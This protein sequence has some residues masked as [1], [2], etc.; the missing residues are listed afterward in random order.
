[1][2]C[3]RSDWR[4]FV[5][6]G[7]AQ[8]NGYLSY[9]LLREASCSTDARQNLPPFSDYVTERVESGSTVVDLGCGPLPK[10]A[11]ISESLFNANDVIGLDPFPSE[12]SGHFIMGIAEFLPLADASVDAVLAAT[13]L[14]HMFSLKATTHE[15]ARVMKPGGRLLIWDH[16]VTVGSARDRLRS[17]VRS[18]REHRVN[19]RRVRVYE[20]GV[21]LPISRGMADPFHEPASTTRRWPGSLQ[22]LLETSGFQQ[23]DPVDEHGFSSYVRNPTS[24]RQAPV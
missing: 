16:P 4:R 20:N 1:M 15:L 13:S 19:G 22:R 2:L 18:A 23:A 12:F 6:W 3:A 7:L 10:P 5:H 9:S 24:S 21:V 11:Y 8:S 17:L 14:D